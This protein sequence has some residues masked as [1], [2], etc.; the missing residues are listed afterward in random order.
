MVISEFEEEEFCFKAEKIKSGYIKNS[1]MPTKPMDK[2]TN[3]D[4]LYQ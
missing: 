2:L 4:E 1:K 3:N